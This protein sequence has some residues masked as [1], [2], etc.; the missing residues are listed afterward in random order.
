MAKGLNA[1]GGP[2]TFVLDLAPQRLQGFHLEHSQ[3]RR[4]DPFPTT[5]REGEGQLIEMAIAGVRSVNPTIKIGVYGE[6]GGD[7]ES[8]NKLLCQD[9]LHVLP[10]FLGQKSGRANLGTRSA[11]IN[12]GCPIWTRCR[13]VHCNVLYIRM[14][15]TGGLNSVVDH[16]ERLLMSR[17]LPLAFQ[18]LDAADRFNGQYENETAFVALVLC[19]AQLHDLG[20]RDLDWFEDLHR[21][22]PNRTQE[23]TVSS[24]TRSEL[25]DAYLSFATDQ[26]DA[27]IERLSR[28][29][30]YSRTTAP[31]NLLFIAHFWKGR[32]H[33]QKGEY[34]T[35]HFHISQ[36]QTIAI[37][38]EAPRLVA[39]TKIHESWLVFQS[40]ERK[41]AFEL[42]DEAEAELKP[43]HHAL[44][45]G[46]IES[47]R[48][49]FVRRSGDY[50]K[51]LE[52]FGKAIQIFER[53]F[54]RAQ[55]LARA[56]VNAAYVKR[57]MA[58]DLKPLLTQR[59]SRRVSNATYLQLTG[60]ALD[61]LRRAAEI[62][63]YSR[64]PGGLGSLFVN[65]G[66]LHLE[67]GDME[68]ANTEAERAFSFAATHSD[69]ILLARTRNLQSAI[70]RACAEEQL[71]DPIAHSSRALQLAEEAVSYAVKT[72]N[73][74]LQAE[75]FI[76]RGMAAV[77]GPTFDIDTAKEYAAKAAALLDPNDRDHLLK[78]LIDLKG[79]I[80]R[81]GDIDETLRQWSNGQ[82]GRKSFVQIQEEF[83]EIVIPKV[84]LSLGRSVAEVSRQ[85]SISPKKVRRILRSAG[86]KD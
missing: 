58:L 81:T 19:G 67:S 7:P 59:S 82:T 20:Y 62:Y 86:C 56:L 40:G 84:W 57:L 65:A 21:R 23:M 33:R 66:H 74:R 14:D 73:K 55:N 46:N 52:H 17:N 18:F 71:G 12:V 44:S 75:S 24:F 2:L 3:G 83:A 6:H 13:A 80:A 77:L 61:M 53:D 43:G 51:A 8:I 34:E 45:L 15:N 48:G 1:G 38:M 64:H 63:K 9:L 50:Q 37:S 70:E 11:E 47:A 85:L 16:L 27:A 31:A 72:Q 76:G 54:P 78:E 68:Q 30:H 41:R 5:N 35:A 28:V 22:L 49:R 79:L 60:E 4:P 42:L 69:P 36:A 26:T 25:I 39:V 10:R 32:A 29:L